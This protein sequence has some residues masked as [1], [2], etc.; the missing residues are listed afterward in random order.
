MK[1]CDRLREGPTL[2]LLRYDAV[3]LVVESASTW[4]PANHADRGRGGGVV[5]WW[6]CGVSQGGRF[7]RVCCAVDNPSDSDQWRAGDAHLALCKSV[8]FCRDLTKRARAGGKELEEPPHASPCHPRHPWP[9]QNPFAFPRSHT[10]SDSNPRTFDEAQKAHRAFSLAR[11]QPGKEACHVVPD[12][13][14]GHSQLGS[15]AGGLACQQLRLL[16]SQMKPTCAAGSGRACPAMWFWTG[17][18]MPTVNPPVGCWLLAVG[19]REQ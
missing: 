19:C 11:L 13:P 16:L 18:G 12:W 4:G 6:P 15:S 14:V 5:L 2:R 17:M 9:C 8:Y 10:P 7:A 3:R 1:R